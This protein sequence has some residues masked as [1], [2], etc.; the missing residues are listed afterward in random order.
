MLLRFALL[1]AVAGFVAPL[2][3]AAPAHAQATRTWVSGVG[4]DLNPCSRTAP[5]KTFAGAISKTA[6]TGEINC[7]DSGGFGAVTIT[8][9]IAILCHG[10]VGGIVASLTTGVIVNTPADAKVILEGL[11]IEGVGN[12]I[13]GVNVL[14]AAKVIINNSTIRNFV[15]EGVNVAGPAGARVLIQN[16]LITGNDGG[17]KVTGVSGAANAAVLIRTTLDNHATFSTRVAT[18]S[19]LILNGSTLGGSAIAI[20][21]VGGGATVISG[22]NNFI[23]GTGLPNVTNTLK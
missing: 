23:S 20:D 12:G 4:D 6:T 22:G 21:N 3:M 17:V 7:L 15:N 2:M 19:V 18:G 10:T 11:D 1:A 13:R 8:K 16:S 9:S 14:S 5:C